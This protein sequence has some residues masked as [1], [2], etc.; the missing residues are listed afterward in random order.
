MKRKEGN[1]LTRLISRIILIIWAFFVLYP[2]LFSILTSLKSNQ[3]FFSGK[4]WD[5]PKWPLLWSN[6]SDTWLRY[7]FGGYFF[8]SIIITLGSLLLALVL[9]TTTAY[10][11]ARYPFKGSGVLYYFYI[12]SLTIPVLMLVIPMFFLFDA[13]HLSNSWMGLILLYSVGAVPFGMFVL[14]SFFKSLP[15][16]LEESAVIDG[17]SLFVV[18]FR[19]MLPLA[20]SGLITIS[21]VNVINIWNEFPYAL[22]LISDP[23]KYTLPVGLSFMQGAM[24]YRTEFGPLFAGVTIATVPVFLMYM[25]FQKRI[26]EGITAGAVK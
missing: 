8:N 26:N 11:L 23:L 10:I 25:L 17:A 18:F 9:T 1:P 7:N 14:V 21:I 15:R 16:E 6:Y 4:S 13:L 5:F 2:L 19:I 20:M 22:I 3:Q 12:A 24:Q